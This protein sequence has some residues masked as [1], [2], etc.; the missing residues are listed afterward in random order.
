MFFIHV[1]IMSLKKTSTQDPVEAVGLLR[2]LTTSEE[3][4]EPVVDYIPPGGHSQQIQLN[5]Q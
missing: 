4:P 1:V 3:Q 2:N 5:R